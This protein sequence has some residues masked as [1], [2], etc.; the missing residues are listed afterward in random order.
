[1]RR[2]RIELLF[3]LTV[4]LFLFAC[5]SEPREVGGI[6]KISGICR[7][8]KIFFKRNGRYGTYKELVNA[9]LADDDFTRGYG[10]TS[11]VQLTE[12]G[13]FGSVIPNDFTKAKMFYVD[14]TGII[15]AHQGNNKIQ[16][17]DPDCSYPNGAKCPCLEN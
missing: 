5:K 6:T 9:N 1:M 15:K 13:Y 8:Q 16:P 3:F 10:Y 17:D 7:G 2:L 4:S 12:K 14:E 11:E